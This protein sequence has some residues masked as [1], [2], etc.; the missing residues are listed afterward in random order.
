MFHVERMELLKRCPN[1]DGDVFRPVRTCID[2]TVSRESFEIV[3][4]P[5]CKLNFTNPRPAAN[6]IG[7]Y[8][9]SP[10][11]ISHSN[12][13]KGLVNSVYQFVRSIALKGKV[14]WIESLN[15][16]SK[17]LLD[18][19][20]G[21]GEFLNEIKNAG[22]MVIGVEPNQNARAMGV[23]NYGLSILEE[24]GL[25]DIKPES[26]DVITMWHV[27]EHVH[28]LQ[29]RVGQ[30]K[31]LLSPGGYAIIAVPNCTSWDAQ[32]YD[33]IWAAYDVPRHL[34]HFS[35]EVIKQM[36]IKQGFAHVKSLPMKFDSF[37]VSMLS[38]KY[39]RSTFPALAGLING[40]RSN[41]NAK[42]DPERY[43]SVVYIFSKP[44]SSR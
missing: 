19:G 9:D 42:N 44:T 1:C 22:Y 14:K 8:Y 28:D 34:Y 25:K 38:S 40:I 13:K 43:S 10:E 30:I 31:T 24:S 11:Y 29:N 16:K 15:P 12:T 33:S 27:L 39:N 26:F 20:C 21:T 2:Y 6:E 3:A 41:R 36:F 35:P 5:S 7:K 17:T 32:K 18:I 23:K 37:Y 4:C